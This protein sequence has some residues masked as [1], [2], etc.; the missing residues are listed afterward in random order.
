MPGIGDRLFHCEMTIQTPNS[1]ITKRYILDIELE[2]GALVFSVKIES[3]L[4]FATGGGD[5]YDADTEMAVTRGEFRYSGTRLVAD[6]SL[7]INNI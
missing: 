4:Y 6:F 7:R 3:T 1:L 2:G 5:G